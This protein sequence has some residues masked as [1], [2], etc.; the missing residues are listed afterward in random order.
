MKSS[1]LSEW[2]KQE[3][4]SYL[5]PCN[6]VFKEEGEDRKRWLKGKIA[7]GSQRP[8]LVFNKEL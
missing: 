1:R 8:G 3:R 5:C 7:K 4:N 6:C 2:N